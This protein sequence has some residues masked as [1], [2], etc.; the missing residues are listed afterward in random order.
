MARPDLRS[1]GRHAATASTAREGVLPGPLWVVLFFIAGVIFVFMLFFA[2]RSE[3]AV[4]QAVLIGSVVAVMVM[5]LLVIRQL[6][7]PFHSGS[8]RAAAGGDDAH[9]RI[10]E[11]EARVA[12]GRVPLLCDA[13]GRPLRLPPE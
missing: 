5:T 7:S 11:Q 3:H 10:L 12:G 1:R 2:D 13:A 4:V 8:R 9:A 6:D